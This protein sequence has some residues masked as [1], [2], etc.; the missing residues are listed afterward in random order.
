MK[1][2]WIPGQARNDKTAIWLFVNYDTASKKGGRFSPA[3]AFAVYCCIKQKLSILSSPFVKGDRGIFHCYIPNIIRNILMTNAIDGLGNHKQIKTQEG[4][5]YAVIFW[6]ARQWPG[7]RKGCCD[8]GPAQSH[9]R[10]RRPRLFRQISF[11]PTTSTIRKPSTA[12]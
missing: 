10:N 12:G 5:S 11:P 8:H 4:K 2:H 7:G 3:G 1:R 6:N 9:R